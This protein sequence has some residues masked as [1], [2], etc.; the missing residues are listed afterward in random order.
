MQ[1][2]HHQVS[3]QVQVWNGELYA[4]SP[5]TDTGSLQVQWGCNGYVVRIIPHLLSHG[6]RPRME[7]GSTM[8]WTSC[9]ATQFPGAGRWRLVKTNRQFYDEMAADSEP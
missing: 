6:V 5:V 2:P 1:L 8:S 9:F 3:V 4:M 7:G